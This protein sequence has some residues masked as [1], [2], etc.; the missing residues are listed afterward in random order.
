MSPS[1]DRSWR[2]LVF[3]GAVAAV[4]LIA[5]VA[6]GSGLDAPARGTAS[7]APLASPSASAASATDPAP[8][9]VVSPSPSPSPGPSPSPEPSP[10]PVATPAPQATSTGFRIDLYRA[11]AFATQANIHYCI[12]GA[13]QIIVNL[14]TGGTDHSA[15]TQDAM[16]AY[17]QQLAVYPDEGDG[18]DPVGWAGILNKFGAGG[19]AWR[20]Y[21]TLADALHHAALRLRLTG[22]PVGL[23]VGKNVEH[24]WVMTGFAA[25]ADPANG[26]FTVTSVA[27]SGPLWPTQRY[28]LGYYDMPPDTWL[29]VARIAPAIRA[30]A[31]TIPTMWDGTYVTVEP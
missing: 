11:S 21:P 5:T 6:F 20:S 22:R 28:Y 1:R 19:Y 27:V 16:Y 29:T 7:G 25:T 30:Y 3:L 17:G 15:A 12:P 18:V 23:Q 4:L 14:V 10:S 26:P 13:S 9:T 31:A 8:S 2:P 24:A